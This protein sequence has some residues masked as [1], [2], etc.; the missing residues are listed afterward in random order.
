VSL[1]EL[2]QL[3]DKLANL[4]SEIAVKRKQFEASIAEL[5][6][7]RT[8]LERDLAA[9]LRA[10]LAGLGGGNSTTSRA[11]GSRARGG[12]IDEEKV[13]AALRKHPNMGAQFIAD[14]L[15]ASAN[16]ISSASLSNKLRDMVQ[17][18][19]LTKE[20]ERR[21]TKYSVEPKG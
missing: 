7:Q 14:Q 20:G 11:P 10:E 9:G 12:K 2:Q 16:G 17:R 8:Q 18:G 13:V 5:R 15:A 19:V 4:D 6:D 1:I 3:K 21:G